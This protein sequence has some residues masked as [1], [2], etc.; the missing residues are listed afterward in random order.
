MKGKKC[1][2][3]FSPALKFPSP[4]ALKA[5]SL[6]PCQSF[7]SCKCLPKTP[8]GSFSPHPHPNPQHSECFCIKTSRHFFPSCPIISQIVQKFYFLGHKVF[9]NKLKSS[10]KSN[11]NSFAPT[12]CLICTLFAPN[13]IY[14]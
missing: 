12:Q 13:L 4:Q 14:L 9:I 8:P 3:H 2:Y 11:S 1:Y 6:L 7:P 5:S 10:L